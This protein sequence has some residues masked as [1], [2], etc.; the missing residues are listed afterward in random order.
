MMVLSDSYRVA[1]NSCGYLFVPDPP[2]PPT[3]I[4]VTNISSCSIRVEWAW[5]QTLPT[6]DIASPDNAVFE[7]NVIGESRWMEIG[8]ADITRTSLDVRIPSSD[9]STRFQLRAKSVS[10]SAGDGS[11]FTVDDTYTLYSQGKEG[12]RG[13]RA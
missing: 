6:S 8:R 11:Y 10:D 4:R 5:P 2:A 9:L 1:D 3:N 13:E 12:T 7:V